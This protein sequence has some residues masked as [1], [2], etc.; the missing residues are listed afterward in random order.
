MVLPFFNPQLCIRLWRLVMLHLLFHAPLFAGAL[1]SQILTNQ[2]R[3][4][5][6]AIASEWLSSASCRR[7]LDDVLELEASGV[8]QECSLGRDSVIDH[9]V[10]RSRMLDLYN[11]DLSGSRYIHSNAAGSADT[12]SELCGL[13]N[14][15]RETLNSAG[16]LLE[17]APFETETHYLSYPNGGHYRRH[18]DVAV[19]LPSGGWSLRGRGA[20]D[21]GS[22]SASEVRRSV[23]FLIYL[24][25]E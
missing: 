1:N 21:G 25:A 8:F 13:V 15:L 23:S 3:E 11:W 9:R 12:R 7:I 18:R 10:R 4:H 6:Y 5:G 14:G 24:N 20:Q 16:F 22:F 2:L 19:T 17:L